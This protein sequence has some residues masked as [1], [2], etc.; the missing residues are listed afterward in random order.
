MAARIPNE[1]KLALVWMISQASYAE[2]MVGRATL[3]VGE[4]PVLP[5]SLFEQEFKWT[6]KTARVF[7]D[8]ALSPKCPEDTG[9]RVKTGQ[10][11]QGHALGHVKGHALG[12]TYLIGL[13]KD[14]SGEGHA[15]GHVK[16]HASGHSS[17]AEEGEKKVGKN[18]SPPTEGSAEG[19]D[20]GEVKPKV[21]MR[22][23]PILMTRDWE[24]NAGNVARAAEWGLNLPALLDDFREYWIRKE[25]RRSDWD[26][27]FRNRM[28]ACV[29][30]EK[31]LIAKNGNGRARRGRTDEDWRRRVPGDDPRNDPLFRTEW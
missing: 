25:T 2:R 4:T 22:R 17:K 3:R 19:G 30:E 31:F 12:H 13:A 24:P 29:N 5:L 10:L 7:L 1:R 20:S 27:S 6:R 15:L 14:T 8:Y 18:N 16:G 23:T 26:G 21:R 11:I 9:V 28:I